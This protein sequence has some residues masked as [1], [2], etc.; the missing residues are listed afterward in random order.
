MHAGSVG[1]FETTFF[2]P[3]KLLG[4]HITLVLDLLMV[5]IPISSEEF[6]FSS[7]DCLP[8]IIYY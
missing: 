4:N 3:L 7:H 8:T 6:L 1:S 5:S 2:Y